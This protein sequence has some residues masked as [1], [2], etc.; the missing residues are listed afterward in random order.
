[1]QCVYHSLS[2]VRAHQEGGSIC[3]GQQQAGSAIANLANPYW[4]WRTGSRNHEIQT[5]GLAS[6]LQHTGRPT[7]RE[8]IKL[9]ESTSLYAYHNQSRA[10]FVSTVR[11]LSYLNGGRGCTF[12]K[13]SLGS[14]KTMLLLRL[15]AILEFTNYSGMA[16]EQRTSQ[17]EDSSLVSARASQQRTERVEVCLREKGI[18]KRTR[19]DFRVTNF[20]EV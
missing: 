8:P 9:F 20:Q 3:Y 17:K 1:M 19:H 13:L 4:D 12:A 14:T 7:I 6:V 11:V 5:I 15:L 10:F 16:T 18:Q 2:R